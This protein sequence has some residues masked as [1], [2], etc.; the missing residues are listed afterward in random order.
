MYNALHLGVFLY[1]VDILACVIK[2]CVLV[3][4]ILIFKTHDFYPL[5]NLKNV[6]TVEFNEY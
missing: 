5:L 1:Y 4:T 3:I 6:I 2:K